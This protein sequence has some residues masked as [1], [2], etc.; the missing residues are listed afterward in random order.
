MAKRDEFL[1]KLKGDLGF[2]PTKLLEQRSVSIPEQAERVVDKTVPAVIHWD[3][4]DTTEKTGDEI[5]GET[6]I[7]TDG[8]FEMVINREISDEAKVMVNYLHGKNP[9][10]FSLSPK[11]D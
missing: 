9:G 8:T 1:A 4:V 6:V 11:E 2:V 7:Y 5:I 3:D 10:N